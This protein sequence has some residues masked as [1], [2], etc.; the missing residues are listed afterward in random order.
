MHMNS[1]VM[2]MREVLDIAIKAEDKVELKPGSYHIMLIELK[3]ELKEGDRVPITLNFDD[4]SSTQI[5]AS[6]RKLQLTMPSGKQ[7]GARLQV[8]ANAGVREDQ[9]KRRDSFPS[10]SFHMGKLANRQ[11]W[12]Q[13]HDT[14]TPFTGHQICRCRRST[15]PILILVTNAGPEL[16]CRPFEGNKSRS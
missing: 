10:R 8:S 5:E 3:V 9:R 7:D 15:L 13:R 4:G 2:K 1:G 6:V 16:I 11:N 12:L 14:A